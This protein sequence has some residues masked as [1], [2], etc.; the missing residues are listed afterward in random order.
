MAETVDIF[1][2]HIIAQGPA[3]GILPV[4]RRSSITVIGTNSITAS[5]TAPAAAWA[6]AMRLAGLATTVAKLDARFVIK[7]GGKADG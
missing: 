5:T 2:P 6:G 1:T 3:V 4:E 7:D